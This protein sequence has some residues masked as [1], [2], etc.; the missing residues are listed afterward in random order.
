[1]KTFPDAGGGIIH[2][3]P[4]DLLKTTLKGSLSG[5]EMGRENG[6]RAS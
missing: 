1:L 2:S 3:A 5:L 4:G 6:D